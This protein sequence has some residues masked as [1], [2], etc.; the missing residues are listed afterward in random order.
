LRENLLVFEQ[1]IRDFPAELFLLQEHAFSLR[2]LGDLLSDQ[3]QV[4]QVD[5]AVHC[6]RD[7]IETYVKLSATVPQNVVYPQEA[8]YSSWMLAMILERAGRI[9]AAEAE[10]RQA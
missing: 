2:H 9:D 4:K 3:G 5:E 1:A 10:Y 7:A 6:Y 8:G